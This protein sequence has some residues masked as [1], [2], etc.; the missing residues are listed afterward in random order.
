VGTADPFVA[1]GQLREAGDGVHHDERTGTWWLLRHA[2]V[3][4]AARDHARFSSVDALP[5]RGTPDGA[6]AQRAA[7]IRAAQGRSL[8]FSDPPV[9]TQLR[10]LLS[11]AFTARATEQMRPTVV[12]LAQELVEGLEAGSEVDLV[13]RV[14]SP[15]PVTVIAEMLGVPAS[16]RPQ[17]AVWSDAVTVSASPMASPEVRERLVPDV[18]AFNAYM[19]EVVEE[20]KATPGDDLISALLAAEIDGERLNDAQVAGMGVL[21]LTAGNETT[22]TLIANA[23]D[24]LLSH[25]DQLDRLQGDPSLAASAVE[26]VLRFAPPVHMFFRRTTEEV[27]Y[28]D[29]TVPADAH[30]MLMVAAANRDPREFPDPEVFDIGRDPNRHVAFGYGVHFCMGAPLARQEAQVVL[31]MLFERFPDLAP[32]AAPPERLHQS[33]APGFKTY[34]VQL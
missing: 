25:P 23:V 34:P 8:L 13:E 9:H 19:A 24:A 17:F 30:V 20:R 6:A 10:A 28:G 7:A 22:R 2:D 33:H 4:A 1:Y 31:P 15:L 29:T 21:L 26:E 11:R 18:V 16:Q 12:R 5:S 27:R 32:G 14:A 3:A